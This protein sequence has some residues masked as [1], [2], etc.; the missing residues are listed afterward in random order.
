MGGIGDSCGC[1]TAPCA[2]PEEVSVPLFE[3]DGGGVRVGCYRV[4]VLPPHQ[5]F[6]SNFLR[7]SIPTVPDSIISPPLPRHNRSS[8]CGLGWP[9]EHFNDDDQELAKRQKDSRHVWSR[10][11]NT[12]WLSGQRYL[13][14][15]GNSPAAPPL[16]F[17]LSSPARHL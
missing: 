5:F 10:K 1:S 11:K 8:Q 15:G 9:L 12:S 13:G 4:R 3:C 16:N 14:E 7:L 17:P 2:E 6:S